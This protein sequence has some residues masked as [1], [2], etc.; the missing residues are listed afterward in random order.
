MKISLHTTA[1]P[2]LWDEKKSHILPQNEQHEQLKQLVKNYF[3]QVDAQKK[4]ELLKEIQSLLTPLKPEDVYMGEEWKNFIF[5]E[6]GNTYLLASLYE[7]MLLLQGANEILDAEGTQLGEICAT[8]GQPFVCTKGCSGC[9][10][11]MVLSS[12]IEALLMALYL[13]ECPEHKEQFIKNFARWKEEAD[14]ISASYVKWGQ[15]FYGEGKDDGSHCREDYYIPCPFLDHSGACY[16]YAVRPYACRSSVAVD[17]RCAEF[18]QTA[19][20]KRQ[21]MYNM[22]FSLYSG[23]D[24]ARQKLMNDIVSPK[25]D[26]QKTIMPYMVQATLTVIDHQ[27]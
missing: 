18:C 13:N 16:I 10:H 15:A 7:Y 1:F 8:Q 21:G 26:L 5:F 3:L 2:L 20:G 27:R 25:K 23:H 4:E 22:L 12:E 9:C 14:S 6:Q 11:Q 24:K 19:Q 17:V